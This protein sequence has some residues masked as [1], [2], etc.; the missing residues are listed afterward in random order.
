MTAFHTLAIPHDN[1]LH[2]IGR[3]EKIY[4]PVCGY[5]WFESGRKKIGEDIDTQ[6]I[7]TGH[8]PR[9]PNVGI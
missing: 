2:V 9:V 8:Q 6:R 7:L 3:K 5:L 4:T 1:F